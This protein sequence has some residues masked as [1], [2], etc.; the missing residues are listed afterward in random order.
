MTTASA[1]AAR[2]ANEYSDAF[3]VHVTGKH[4]GFAIKPIQLF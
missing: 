3:V 2:P 1:M 4:V